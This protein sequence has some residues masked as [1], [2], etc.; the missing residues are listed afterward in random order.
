MPLGERPKGES[1]MEKGSKTLTRKIT[2]SAML[3]AIGVILQFFEISIP[4]VPNFIKLDFSDL[5]GFIGA[6]VCGPLAGVMIIKKCPRSK[7]C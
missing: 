4:V 7:A 5:P 3:A 2:I 6:F 1:N